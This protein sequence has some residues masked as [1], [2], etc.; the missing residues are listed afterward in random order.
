MRSWNRSGSLNQAGVEF[1]FQIYAGTATAI[2]VVGHLARD[3]DVRFEG[4]SFKL[5]G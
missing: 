1:D 4:H 5:R 2:I 3:A